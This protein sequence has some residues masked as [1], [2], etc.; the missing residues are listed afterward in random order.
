[1]GSRIIVHSKIHDEFVE[2]L[3]S[4]VRSFKLGYP[5]DPTTQMGPVISSKQLVRIEELVSTSKTDG[6]KIVTGGKRPSVEIFPKGHFYEPT[7]IVNVKSSHV[8]AREEIFGPVVVV[9]KV[10]GEDEA[11]R[12]ANDSRFG[13]GASVWTQDVKRA[14]RVADRLDVGIV[15]INSH[16]NNDPSSPWGGMKE[17]G[18]GRENGIEAYEEY[19]ES[20]SVVVNFGGATDWFGGGNVRYG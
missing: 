19:T 16:H 20:K 18:M 5:L 14:H 6:S 15:W 8:L 2:R 4:K 17:S 7:V 12:V 11:V 1:M 13:L 10:E 9:I 3:V